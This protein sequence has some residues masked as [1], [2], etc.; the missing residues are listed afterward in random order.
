MTNLGQ[1]EC[2]LRQ[3]LVWGWAHDQS[4]PIGVHLETFLHH[5]KETERSTS[6]RRIIAWSRYG[7]RG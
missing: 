1:S 3:R 7:E 4:G 2:I 5:R 6:A